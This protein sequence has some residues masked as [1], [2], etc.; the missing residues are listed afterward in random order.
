[1]AKQCYRC[2]ETKD[3]SCFYKDSN[4]KDGLNNY[5]IECKKITSREDYIK[6]RDKYRK[7]HRE[8]YKNNKSQYRARDARR[9]ASELNATPCWL[10]KDQKDYMQ[11]IYKVCAKVSERTG[12]QHH[13]DHIVPLKGNN[14]CGLHVPWNLSIIPAPMNLQ[15]G[16]THG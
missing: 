3:A 12:K 5:C 4:R 8:H 15:K 1:M 6:S 7:R 14:V 13:V 16:N 9:R 10:T 11:R 2:K